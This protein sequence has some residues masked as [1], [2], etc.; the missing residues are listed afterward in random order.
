M[1]VLLSMPD[2][3]NINHVIYTPMGIQVTCLHTYIFMT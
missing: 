2:V 3:R 1:N